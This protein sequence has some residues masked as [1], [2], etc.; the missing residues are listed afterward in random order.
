MVVEEGEVRG[1]VGALKQREMNAGAWLK[2]FSFIQCRTPAS[3]TM[4]PTVRMDI[5]IS[6]NII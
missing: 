5:S 3:G 4:P 6:I 2:I 1:H